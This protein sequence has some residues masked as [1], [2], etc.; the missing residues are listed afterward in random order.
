MAPRQR[1]A[2]MQGAAQTQQ[3][4]PCNWPRRC[5]GQRRRDIGDETAGGADAGGIAETLSKTETTQ[6]RQRRQSGGRGRCGDG[7]AAHLEE[8][9]PDC[10]RCRW[11]A[12]RRIDGRLVCPQLQAHSGEETWG[13][14]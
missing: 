9:R 4:R 6:T 2:Q 10:V 13:R 3:W 8:R 11:R 14:E 7:R 1:A 5:M 12:T